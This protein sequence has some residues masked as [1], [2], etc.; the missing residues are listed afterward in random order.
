MV[1]REF[2]IYSNEGKTSPKFIGKNLMKAGRLDIVVN[3]IIQALFVS[4]RVRANTKVHVFLYGSPDPP[5]LITISPKKET[6]FSKKDL[7]E[8]IRIALFKY[9]PNR[10][11][12]ALP[13]VYVQKKH[14]EDF[15]AEQENKVLFWLDKNGTF[16]DEVD[17]NTFPT[18]SFVFF[19]GDH[20]GLP[21]YVKSLLRKKAYRLSL[22]RVEYFTSQCVTILNFYLDK[23]FPGEVEFLER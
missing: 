8:L 13:G 2:V 20:L 17:F 18:K 16:I 11:V 10:V 12:E 4:E 5:R 9:K 19:L 7:G 1:T 15:I 21:R 22:G 14:I 23:L 3:S 6:P